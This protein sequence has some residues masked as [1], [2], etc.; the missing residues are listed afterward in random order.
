ME[1]AVR[2]VLQ[3]IKPDTEILVVDNASTDDTAQAAAA[4][5]A[6]HECVSVVCESRLGLSFARNTAL[7]TARGQYVIFLDDDAIAQPGWLEEYSQFFASPPADK[8][9]CVGGAV[10]PCYDR[11]PPAWMATG[12]HTLRCG[13]I[14]QPVQGKAGPWGCNVAYS[15]S[16]VMEAGGFCPELGRKGNFWGAHEESELLERLRA[17]GHRAWWLP[18]AVI[19]HYYPPER[20]RLGFLCKTEFEQG[21]SSALFWLR[22]MSAGQQRW[23]F[24]CSRLA[25]APFHLGL[26]LLGALAASPLRQGQP[27]VRL[28]LKAAR[29]AGMAFELLGIRTGK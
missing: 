13:E 28:L 15:R 18:G 27:T 7:M 29:I 8:I 26:C 6:T 19:K 14:P 23:L 12:A 22:T 5:A 17:A 2:S 10:I 21:R 16:A 9:A 20:L 11:Q 3:Q 4:L 24:L 25:T 1:A